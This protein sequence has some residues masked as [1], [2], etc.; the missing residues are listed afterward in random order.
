MKSVQIPLTL[1][2][3]LY[4]YFMLSD[5][6]HEDSIKE[7]LQKKHEKIYKHVLYTS[8][9]TAKTEEEREDARQKYLDEVGMR[10][11]FRY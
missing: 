8:S 7:Q 1:F 4:S 6:R 2:L 9:K 3:K 10:E 5:Y 11:S